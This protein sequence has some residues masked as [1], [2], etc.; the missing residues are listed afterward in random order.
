[1]IRSSTNGLRAG[2]YA[3]ATEDS[4][5]KMIMNNERIRNSFISD[6]LG[7][8]V[9]FSEVVDVTMDPVVKDFHELFK[10]VNIPY[11]KAMMKEIVDGKKDNLIPNTLINRA[12]PAL[13]SFT[14]RL[15]AQIYTNLYEVPSFERN[16]QLDLVCKTTDSIINIEIQQLSRPFKWSELERDPDISN[17]ISRVVGISMFEK[18]PAYSSQAR[19]YMNWYTGKPWED[20]DIQRHFRLAERKDSNN[21]RPEWLD[22]FATSQYKRSQYVK[23]LTTPELKEAY[24]LVDLANWEDEI[25]STYIHD[26]INKNN[27]SQYVKAR[28]ELAGKNVMLRIAKRMFKQGGAYTSSDITDIAGVSEQDLKDAIDKGNEDKLITVKILNKKCKC[29]C[30]MMN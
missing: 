24:H 17:K 10:M 13:E 1:M 6:I 28:K 5:F 12:C 7:E 4:A 21:V 30:D 25:A 9:K 16:T 11:V 19:Q 27:I 14:D 8:K 20:E 26:Q 2:M 23:R 3:Q 29:A 22:F 15:V 18:D